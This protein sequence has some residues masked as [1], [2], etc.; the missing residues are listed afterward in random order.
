MVSPGWID[1]QAH[2]REPGLETKEGMNSG[3]DAAS[4]GGFTHVAVLPST[5][6]C[7]DHASAVRNTLALGT[8]AQDAGIPAE[9]LALACLSE[10]GQGVQLAEMHDMSEAGAVAFTDD[11]PLDRV[12]LLQR[13]LTYS[14]V[15][16]KVVVDV[17]L[18]RDMNAGGL[19][20][21]GVYSTQMGLIGIP[22]EAETLRVSRDLDVLKYAGGRLH[23][24]TLTCADSVAMVR[25]AKREGLQVTCG[26][27][28]AHLMFCD[29]DLAGFVGT[30]RVPSP[31]RAQSDRDAL[32]EG[33]LDGT[34]DMVVSDH[35]PEDLEH[36]DV[37]FMLSPDGMATL[38]SAFSLALSGLKESTSDS[39]AAVEALVS[40]MTQ[41][42][43]NVLSLAPSHL[44]AD[45]KCDL[46]WFHPDMAHRSHGGTKGV[47]LP[48]LKEGQTGQ[49]LGVFH[50]N[51]SWTAQG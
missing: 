45:Q 21:E 33:V 5:S 49:V 9:A 28:A 30:L 3:L 12:S 27:T 11:T 23:L 17:P 4:R 26:T 1:G 46:T 34:I 29:E 32:R 41:G 16:G 8:Q 10:G 31:F 24:A 15:H 20:H 48:P 19:M 37:E 36:H 25:E 51:R 42:P 39:K 44:E 50:A 13:A 43:R 14:K 18:D 38:P 7:V 40:A 35:R 2:F 47:N 22:H 6:P